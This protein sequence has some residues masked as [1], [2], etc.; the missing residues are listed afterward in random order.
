MAAEIVV[1][2]RHGFNSAPDHQQQRCRVKLQDVYQSVE[3][4][5]L[6]FASWLARICMRAAIRRAISGSQT[7]CRRRTAQPVCTRQFL[8][9]TTPPHTANQAATSHHCIVDANDI[10]F[11][12]YFVSHEKYGVC[13]EWSPPLS[14]PRHPSPRGCPAPR[15]A[16]QL[17]VKLSGRDVSPV[18]SQWE[19]YTLARLAVRHHSTGKPA[20]LASSP[21]PAVFYR[22]IRHVR[23]Q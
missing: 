20:A 23:Y 9:A 13:W 8:P 14:P 1:Q 18:T 22:L 10:Q 19:I 16:H 7:E 17:N 12:D 6:S 3:G 4:K 2:F 11:G 21:V 15:S 5:P